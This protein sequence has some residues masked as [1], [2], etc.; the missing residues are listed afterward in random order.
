M[1]TNTVLVGGQPSLYPS[2]KLEVADLR[3]AGA[4]LR[5]CT[6][7]CPREGLFPLQY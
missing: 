4:L 1:P 3:R 2:T 5:Y 7:E 6:C